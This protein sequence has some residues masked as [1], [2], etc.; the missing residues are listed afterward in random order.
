VDNSADELFYEVT[1]DPDHGDLLLDGNLL[2]DGDLFTQDDIDQGLLQYV[3]DEDAEGGEFYHEWAEGT[4]EWAGT[5]IKAEINPVDPS[6]LT[7][8]DGG[9]SVTINYESK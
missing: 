6:N 8:P 7:L 9:E 1:D 3:V 5:G 4:P 2:G